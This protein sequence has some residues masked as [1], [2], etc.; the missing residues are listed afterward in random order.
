MTVNGKEKQMNSASTNTIQLQLVWQACDQLRARVSGR[1]LTPQDEGYEAERKAWNLTVD[2]Y[3][4][5]IVVAQNA[6]DIVEAVR[7]AREQDLEVAVKSTGHGVIR[8]ANDSL[9]IVTS[10][11]TYVRVDAGRQTAW[12]SAGAKWGDVLGVAQAVGLAPLLGSSPD[13]GAVG[14]T[15]GGGMGWLAR[16]YGISAD[17]VNWFE[18]VTADGNL[19][20]ASATENADLFWGLRG[21][22]GNFGVVTGMEVRLYPVTTIYGGNLFYPIHM[23]AEVYAQYRRWIAG[24]PDELTSSVV[25]MNYPPFP[26]VPE[27]L[28]GQSFAMLRVSFCGPVQ[29]GEELMKYWRAWQAPLRD[30][31][32]A[33]PFSQVAAI[34]NDPVDPV[35][36]CSSGAWLSDLGEEVADILFRY[37]VLRNAPPLLMF[38]ETRHAGGAISRVD[39]GAAAFGN[40]DAL[41]SLQVVGAA[42]TRPVWAAVRHHIAELKRE[43][44]AH[45]HGG[46]YL[47]FLE[48]DEAVV[49]TRQGFS[50]GAFNRLRQLKTRYDPQNLFSHGYD[51]P[52]MGIR[53]QGDD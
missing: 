52:P 10:Q 8:E 53:I 43:L 11:M 22:G 40:R 50:P 31:V 23:A 35:A 33:M 14:Y 9:L 12:I 18:L 17:S 36:S 2:Q 38:A 28:R 4:A 19:V 7:F 32:K 27:F 3:P 45:L 24:A 25:L 42:P 39:P 16:K 5:L 41:Y 21:G 15:L 30:D 29:Q 46:V 13:V 44:S 51:I 20:R 49:R 1:V 37:V 48:G 26:Q 47:N 6:N 34:S